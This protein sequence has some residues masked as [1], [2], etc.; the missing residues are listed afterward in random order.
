MRGINLL[1]FS[2]CSLFCVLVFSNCASVQKQENTLALVDG[3]PVT[4]D[5]LGYS[6]QVAHRREELSSAKTLDIS[7]YI[8]KLIDDRLIIQEARRM[9][10]ENSPDVQAKIREYIVRES[11]VRLYDEE[12]VVKASVTEESVVNYY[13]EKY[14]S[15]TLNVIEAGSEDEAKDI[16]QKL[17]SGEVFEKYALEYESH[18]Q[19]K[20]GR[21]LVVKR[22]TLRP[23]MQEA[24]S[25]LKPG[26]ISG[27]IKDQDK[28]YIIKLFARQPAP[29]EDLESARGEIESI[30]KEQK[31]KKRS[32]EYLIQ[33][34]EKADMKIDQELLASIKLDDGDVTRAEWLNDKRTLVQGNNIAL[35]VADF[36]A[37][38]PE[39]IVDSKEDIL[40][41][42]LDRKLVDIEALSRHYETD[43]DLKDMVQR[44]RNE[45]IK[46]AFMRTVIRSQIRISEKDV[47]AYYLSHQ[48]DYVKPVKYRIQ[49]ITLKSQENA[50]EVLNSLSGGANFSWLAKAK[51]Q[52]S[53][54]STGGITEW[55]T[56]EQ[57]P[58]PVREIVDDLKQGDIGPILKI[59]SEYLIFRLMEKS[60][61][62]VEEFSSVKPIVF[63]AVYKEKFHEIYD[64][65]I[66]KLRKDAR[67]E[68]NNEAIRV[69]EETFKK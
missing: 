36:V 51:S 10:L 29:D 7:Q 55:K 5:D 57:L 43:T 13:K 42:W 45:L 49:Q 21:E 24:V 61:Q 41:S 56:K 39:P 33:L 1:F 32:D 44:Y 37:V 6:L 3:E 38:L 65:Y 53:L 2:L 50:N 8:Q 31:I 35:T 67:I 40:N 9:G 68:L 60:G 4:K 63:N 46:A 62:E 66:D 58:V 22:K 23:V 20:D 69:F 34:R 11:V 14:E 15:F 59:D 12:I 27:I 52:D 18:A 26:E 48:E 47:E 16:L 54:A 28:Y 25:D 17:E 30:L 64:G 19:K